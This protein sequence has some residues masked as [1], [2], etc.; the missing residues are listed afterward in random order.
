LRN[1][2]DYDSSGSLLTDRQWFYSHD[3]RAAA[4]ALTGS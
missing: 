1:G 3:A 4:A 2:A